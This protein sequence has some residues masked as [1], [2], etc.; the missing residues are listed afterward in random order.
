MGIELGMKTD[1]LIYTY[2]AL[3]GMYWMTY[4][5]IF[6][7]IAVFMLDHGFSSGH[8]GIVIAI[9]SLCSIM[10]QPRIASIADKGDRVTLRQM[11][12]LLCCATLV[13]IAVVAIP[14][15]PLIPLAIAYIVMALL[16]LSFQPLLSALGVQLI[17][18]DVP[19]NFSACRS[20]GSAGFSGM[21]FVLGIVTAKFATN[22]LPIIAFMQY[23][24]L[25]LL[26]RQFPDFGGNGQSETAQ[27]GTIALLKKEPAYFVLLVGI[28]LMF[29]S[30]SSLNNYMYQVL[31]DIGKGNKE[32]GHLSAFS[33][34]IEV[35]GLLLFARFLYK[36]DYGKLIR[37]SSLFFTVKAVVAAIANT[38]PMLYFAFSFQIISFAIFTPAI[39]YYVGLMISKEDQVKGQALITIC[40][41]LGGTLGSL[42]SG[43][44]IE[45][46]GVPAMKWMTAVC[47]CIG[48]I[49][50]F[51]GAKNS[52]NGI[53]AP[54]PLETT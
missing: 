36:F 44:A 1:K 13:P 46:S 11:M 5:V 45:L 17:Q 31:V 6:G 9:S 19:L 18:N 8:V 53:N 41:A 32:L 48:M 47:C 25:I 7:F 54:K 37:Y 40:I 27:G 35:P 30:H 24:I 21:V 22:F 28:T 39:V 4:G 16:H 52:N 14:N 51:L 33:S 12:L 43:Y 23:V 3:Q 34:V 26:I 50:V 29:I 15:L 49:F 42:I 2:A 20:L 10:I 38:L